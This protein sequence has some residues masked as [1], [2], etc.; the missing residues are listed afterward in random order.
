MDW[1]QHRRSEGAAAAFVSMLLLGCAANTDHSASG[2][3]RPW[4]GE[5]QVYGSL[6]GMHH[7]GKTGAMVSLDSLLPNPNL[8]AL[9]ALADLAGEVTIVGGKA[10][11]SY[12]VGAESL[13]VDVSTRTNVAATLFVAAEVPAWH[14][15]VTE[16]RISFETL[17]DE[18]AKL[19]TAAG[20]SLDGRFPFLLEGDF[21]DLRWHVIDGRRL[22]AGETSHQDHL[23]AA[24]QVKRDRARATLVGFYSASDQ[25]IFTH[26][27]SKTH[28]H[29]T[30]D[31]PSSTGHVD[32]VVIPPGTKVM[33]PAGS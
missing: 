14:S 33:F 7:E 3:S 12:P 27:G 17:D 11:V 25:G 8:Y 20:M 18:I 6:A 22:P 30:L 28:I 10:F 15:V 23:D 4:N 2:A 16:H 19:A 24:V 13:R 1:F 21:E 26:M 31:A 9:G 29:C 5:V 32:H